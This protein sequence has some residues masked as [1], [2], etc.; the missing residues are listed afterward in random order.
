MRVAEAARGLPRSPVS[1]RPSPRETLGRRR[2]RFR[3]GPNL[4]SVREEAEENLGRGDGE[5]TLKGKSPREHPA[6]G[7][8]TIRRSQGIPAGV[9]AQKPRP[10]GP[11]SRLAR[12]VYRREKRHVGSPGRKRTGYPAGG[13]RSEGR[14]PRALPA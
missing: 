4:R 7:G 9:K 3:K 2:A 12:D 5:R 11:A 14:I 1:A 8:L 13:E 6:V 10:V